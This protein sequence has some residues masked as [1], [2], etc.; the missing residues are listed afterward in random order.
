M[1]FTDL[2]A[3]VDAI[4]TKPGY[5]TFVEAATAGTPV[6]YLQRDLWPEQDVLI[7][8]LQQEVRCEEISAEEFSSGQLAGKLDRLWSLPGKQV[9]A[10][11]AGIAA[12]AIAAQLKR[13][14][15]NA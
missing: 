5:G 8:W 13:N 1:P 12:E 6:L 15:R 4:V 14:S 2:L 11:G 7:E 9:S 10:N 3:S